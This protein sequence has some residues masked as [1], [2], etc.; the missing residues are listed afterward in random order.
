MKNAFTFTFAAAAAALLTS[1]GAAAADP[2]LSSWASRL[3]FDAPTTWAGTLETGFLSRDMRAEKGFEKSREHGTVPLI[4]ARL[5]AVR[6][7]WQADLVANYASGSLGAASTPN[8]P[9]GWEN[10]STSVDFRSLDVAARVGYTV[11][12]SAARGVALTPHAGLRWVR[13]VENESSSLCF[14]GDCIP[15]EH[16]AAASRSEATA[17]ALL[18]WQVSARASVFVD[19]EAGWML[20]PTWRGV[21]QTRDLDRHIV[22]RLEIGGRYSLP[23]DWTASASL[24]GAT[25]EQDAPRETWEDRTTIGRVHQLELVAGISRTF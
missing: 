13:E 9:M 25:W 11:P 20:N 10:A 5:G 12:L 14:K 18:G 21:G 6:G 2:D 8:A 23:K 22:E 15:T 17:G 4:S 16:T 3:N 24:R 1:F 7:Q 19:A